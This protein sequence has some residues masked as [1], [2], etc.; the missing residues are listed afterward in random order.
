MQTTSLNTLLLTAF[1][2]LLFTATGCDAV[3][4]AASE[5]N[6]FSVADDIKL[7]QQTAAQIAAAPD[8]YPILNEAK[9]GQVYAY[10]TGIRD[11]I[12]ATGRV[13]NA[14]FFQWEVKIIQD[15]KTLNA[16]CTPGGY[17]YVYTG[18]IKYLDSEDQLAGVMGH[19]MAHADLRHS[20][21]QMTTMYGIDALASM[22]AG[23]ST[24]KMASQIGEQLIGLSFSREH[25]TEADDNSVKYL[26]GTGYKADGFAEFFVKMSSKG[27]STPAFLSTHPS[28]ANRVADIRANAQKLHCTG[29]DT[30]ATEYAKIKR[31]LP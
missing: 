22:V 3:K 19:E 4:Q 16:F 7:G 1:A 15:D 9:Y 18:L 20:T 13:K 29:T 23:T 17:I 12:L 11:R 28:P 8:K 2:A 27:G 5:V 10:V 14:R 31:A 25:E 26:C 30:K 24:A 6:T 21:R